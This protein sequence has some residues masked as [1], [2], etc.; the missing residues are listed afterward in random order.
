[1]SAHN[2]DSSKSSRGVADAYEAALINPDYQPAVDGSML[3]NPG[4]DSAD[5]RYPSPIPMYPYGFDGEPDTDPLFSL[6]P[7][8]KG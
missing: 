7:K 2:P 6:T 5:D 8:Q 4:T 3:V 1:M